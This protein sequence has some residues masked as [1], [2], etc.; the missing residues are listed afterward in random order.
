M[1]LLSSSLRVNLISLPGPGRSSCMESY[2]PGSTY[3]Y[4]GAVVRNITLVI[5]RLA[6]NLAGRLKKLIKLAATWLSN[7]GGTWM[8]KK[9]GYD[10]KLKT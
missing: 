10:T 6:V 8:V 7:M 1:R 5:R 4:G 9:S 3:L 2:Q